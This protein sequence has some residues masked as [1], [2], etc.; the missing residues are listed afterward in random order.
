MVAKVATFL[1]TMVAART[2]VGARPRRHAPRHR[3]GSGLCAPRHLAGPR[4][5]LLPGARQ[6]RGPTPPGPRVGARHRRRDDDCCR[7]RCSQGSRGRHH[8][9]AAAV[10]L[11]CTGDRRC[12]C[13]R[14]CHSHRAQTLGPAFA[15]PAGPRLANA[16]RTPTNAGRVVAAVDEAK[17]FRQGRYRKFRTHGMFYPTSHLR[18]RIGRRTVQYVLYSYRVDRVGGSVHHSC[19]G[20][21]QAGAREGQGHETQVL[22]RR[23]GLLG[24]SGRHAA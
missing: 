5:R 10:G 7:S 16:R 14:R 13:P 20:E 17:P 11:A 19:P 8:R 21:T 9:S 12:P 3:P 18:P 1:A 22:L 23:P 15:P 6:P 24:T 4:G 2:R